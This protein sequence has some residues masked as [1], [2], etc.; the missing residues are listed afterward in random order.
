[1]KKTFLS[2]L[3]VGRKLGLI[4]L[5]FLSPTIAALIF[6]LSS[7]SKDLRVAGLELAGNHYQRPLEALLD[8]V[9][10]HGNLLWRSKAAGASV[11]GEM[12][13]QRAKVESAL[14]ALAAADAEHGQG[15]QFTDAGLAQRKREHFR[16][17][18]VAREWQ[19]LVAQAGSMTP[20]EVTR[21][22]AHLVQDIRTMIT[23]VG[24]T[25]NLILDPDLDSYYVMDAT[26]VA[27]PQTQQRIAEMAALGDDVLR[28]S[29]LTQSERIAFAR[30]AAL[31]RESDLDKV[32]GDLET[33]RNEDK[34]F[35]GTSPSLASV[36]PP[37]GE[38]YAQAGKELEELARKVADAPA[39]SVSA[40]QF[41]LKAQAARRASF[42]LW[43]AAS[44][45]L[46]VLLQLRKA[47]F[48]N[49]RAWGVGV[50]LGFL[51]LAGA[52][53][54]LVTRSLVG[55]LEDTVEVLDAMAEGDFRNGL[56]FQS[57]DELGR[58]A[59]ALNRA[60][61]DVRTALEQ[62]QQ[63]AERVAASSDQLSEATRSIAAGAEEQAAGLEQTSATLAQVSNNAEGN[64]NNARNAS[65]LISGSL[66]AA[67]AVNATLESM[68]GSMREIGEASSRIAEVSNTI[69]E[70]A[71]QTNLLAL[72]AAVEAARA[73]EQGRGFAVVA[74][75]VR[76]LAV[77]SA[78]ASKEIRNLIR[79]SGEKIG[80]GSGL[81]GNVN[82]QVVTLIAAFRSVAT[83]VN[84][85]DS[86]SSEQSSSLGQVQTAATQINQV[87]QEN[88]AHTEELAATATELSG[89]AQRLR[90]AVARFQ[91]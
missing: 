49:M 66:E 58:M 78:T 43:D 70:F 23:H 89:E 91:L 21:Q 53:A 11:D 8:G 57:R 32:A 13:A 50:T 84:E 77:R 47:Y 71:F 61:A 1:L 25:S 26:L 87:T 74:S 7:V 31:L 64:A 80:K 79:D 54:F 59:A 5:V 33:A 15:L 17:E 34:N 83:L 29:A 63:G 9:G 76:S 6:G 30:F 19:S 10:E 45:E 22:H 37:L 28:R 82:E 85:I 48:E 27:L 75:E 69:D 44:G 52:L 18:N 2:N 65:K 24:D 20:E 73:G 12:Q 55:T 3:T 40:E 81:A 51:G 46:E 62:A 14:Q 67:G 42:D 86:R 68:L 36:L 60:I 4:C 90:T 56:S 88:S 38:R 41:R 72:N 35:Y 16:R 39:G